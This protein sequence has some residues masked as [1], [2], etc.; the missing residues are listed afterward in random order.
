MRVHVM[1]KAGDAAAVAAGT[2]RPLMAHPSSRRARPPPLLPRAGDR[3][4]T[5]SYILPY[6]EM[7]KAYGIIK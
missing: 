3:Y 5:S 4:D 6:P 2:L 7:A 1:R